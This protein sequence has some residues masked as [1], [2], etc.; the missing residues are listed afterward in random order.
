MARFDGWKNV[1]VIFVFGVVMAM[2]SP[3]QTF[4]SL[5]SFQFYRGS[6]P[7]FM[8]LVQGRDGNLYGTTTY[9]GFG[10]SDGNGEVFKI[11]PGGTLT[12]L[13]RFLDRDGANPHA[14][15]VQS[16]NGN[17]YGTTSLGGNLN[18]DAPRGCG[19]VFEITSGGTLRTLHN[20]DGTDGFE[21]YGALVQTT[22]GNFYG[23][24][25]DTVFKMTPGGTLTTLYTFC[26]QPP[27][28]DGFDVEAGLVQAANGN[29]YGTTYAGG[30]ASCGGP[31][32]CGTVFEITPGGT[33]T[34]LYRFCAQGWAMCP[35]GAFPFTGLARGRDGSLYGTTFFYG[36]NG[37]GTIFKIT[38]RGKFT[39]LYAFDDDDTP[40]GAGLVQG[41]DGN[42]YGTTTTDGG[43][44]YGTIFKITPQGELATL[45]AFCP[46]R[47]CTDGRNPL[48]GLV[49]ATDGNFYGTTAS[50]GTW[51]NGTV[52]SLSVGLGPFIET[53]PS[54]GKV[55]TKVIILGNNLTGSTSVTFNGTAASFTVVSSTEIT[56]TVPT[57]AT[58][59]TVNVATPGGTLKSNLV[60]RVTK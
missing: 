17:F 22:N 32:G 1:F 11:T 39:L 18:C 51:G 8:S 14:G 28:P 24:T 6:D 58:S 9:G 49:Q 30:N 34:T 16:T 40:W 10:G 3:A 57:G 54:A 42:F 60:F 53:L 19:T 52:F 45:Y 2:A 41:T 31:D 48:G 15:L 37:A 43:T 23:T 13:H 4:T 5:V 38:T 21:P 25:Y 55:G 27:C 44:S 35:D 46:Q 47:G 59:G 56:T 26:T 50:G 20:F 7:S 29:F 33:L 12:T 36:P